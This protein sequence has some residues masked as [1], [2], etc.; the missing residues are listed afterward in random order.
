M[1]K[2]RN[3]T[4]MYNT[5]IISKDRPSLKEKLSKLLD[6]DYTHG[7]EQK[8]EQDDEP[9]WYVASHNKPKVTDRNKLSFNNTMGKIYRYRRIRS[10]NP[11]YDIFIEPEKDSWKLSAIE[12]KQQKLY[13][14]LKR[15]YLKEV[16]GDVQT[17]NKRVIESEQVAIKRFDRRDFKQAFAFHQHSNIVRLACL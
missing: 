10:S 3:L 13:D 6:V 9:R 2:N 4:Q 1:S 8:Q 7:L 16:S 17:I 15:E 12:K 5:R 11:D 14:K